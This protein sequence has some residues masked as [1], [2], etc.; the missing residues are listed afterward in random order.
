MDQPRKPRGRPR[1]QAAV[2]PAATDAPVQSLDRALVLLTRLADHDGLSLTEAAQAAD[3]SP[4]TCYRMLTTLAAHGF[5]ANDEAEGRWRIGV[6]L[7]RAGSAFARHTKVVDV[8]RPAMRMVM[9]AT[10]ETA[11]L[12]IEQDGDVVVI[13]QIETHAAIRA[14]FRP[15]TRGVIHASGIGKALL[16]AFPADRTVAILKRKPL[17]ALTH[18]TITEPARLTQELAL[19]R[20]RGWSLDDE[21]AAVGMRCI[22]AAIY[23]MHGEAVAGVSI[24]GPSVRMPDDRVPEL[25]QFVI[26]A[27]RRITLAM[28]GQSPN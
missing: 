11:N 6:G 18:R 16:A 9:E 26:E 28:G 12:G 14:F 24:S 23:N 1:K 21:E 27:A 4:A 5:V 3:L 15:G 25:A 19:I 20:A 7:Y 8:S 13:S 10:G 22:A 2:S 17:T